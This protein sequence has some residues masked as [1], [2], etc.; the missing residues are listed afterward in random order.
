MTQRF[1]VLASAL[2]ALCALTACATRKPSADST[3]ALTPDTVKPAPVAMQ[4]SPDT[5]K[6]TRAKTGAKTSAKSKTTTKR[7]STKTS[8]KQKSDSILGR[9]SV[10]RFDPKDPRRQ[11]PTIPPK[12]PPQER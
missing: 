7:A 8:A 2:C 1:A 10:I 5:A 11:L 12:K 4:M 6:A 3:A 9:D